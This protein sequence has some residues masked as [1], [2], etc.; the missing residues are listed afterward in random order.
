[1][2]S[3]SVVCLASFFNPTQQHLFVSLNYKQTETKKNPHCCKYCL[4]VNY[5]VGIKIS[6]SDLCVSL[7]ELPMYELTDVV[8]LYCQSVANVS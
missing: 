3:V 8:S 6:F 5:S 7:C 2:R 1:M 4:T